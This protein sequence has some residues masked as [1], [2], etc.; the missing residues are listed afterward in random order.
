MSAVELQVNRERFRSR[1]RFAGKKSLQNRHP[2][3][4]MDDFT[5]I[6]TFIKVVEAGSFS[7]AARC[8]DSSISAVARQ[9][10]SLEEELGIRLLNRSTRSLSL[11]EP[12]RLFFERVRTISK[13][14][15]NAKSEATS[16]QDSVKGV[17]RVSLRVSTG[18][19]IIVPALPRLVNQYPE[20]GFDISLTDERPDLIANNID[21]AV[22]MGHIPDTEIVARRLTRSERIVCAS[23]G[24]FEGHG[25]PV[26]PQDLRHHNCLLYAARSYGNIWEFTKNGTREDIEVNGN[27]RSDNGLVLISAAMAG[28]GILVAQEWTVRLPVSRNEL[29]RT[30][31]EYTVRPRAE[32]SELYVV[33]PSSRGLSR[34]VRIFVDFLVNLF[35]GEEASTDAPCLLADVPPN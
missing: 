2:G 25:V 6:Q 15:R 3:W 1:V 27:L 35:H 11:T 16:F 23:P 20:L 26:T 12:G 13:E 5:R 17:L 9:I 8:T 22:W 19:T 30:M 33:Y 4:M 18:T 34:K 14:L 29:A 7:A 32:D 10:Q 24:Y 31:S 21:V 28:I